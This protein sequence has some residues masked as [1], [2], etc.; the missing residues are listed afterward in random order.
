MWL[1]NASDI[2]ILFY[3]PYADI[4]TEI[5]EDDE[6]KPLT[7]GIFGEWGAGKSTLLN[8]VRQNI[9]SQPQDKKTICI[10]INAWAFEGYEDAK[11]AVMQALLQKLEESAPN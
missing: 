1:D 9:E 4:V 2:D 11:I 5:A 3:K 8:L 6:Y 7:I 10:D